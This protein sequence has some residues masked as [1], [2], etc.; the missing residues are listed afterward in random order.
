MSEFERLL[1]ALLNGESADITP[2][3]RMEKFLKNCVDKCGCDDL[4][5]P[6]TRGEVLLYQLAEQMASGGGSSGG[7]LVG[8]LDGTA[9][10]LNNNDITTLRAFAIENNN[11]LEEVTLPNVVS[12]GEYAFN[13]CKYLKKASMPKLKQADRSVF[14]GCQRLTDVYLPLL[15]KASDYMFNSCST[16]KTL[17]LPSVKSIGQVGVGGCEQLESVNLPQVTETTRSSFA[18]NAM[19]TTVNAPLL[20]TLENY[21]FQNCHSIERLDFSNLYT[22]YGYAFSA[23]NSLKTLILRRTSVVCSLKSTNAFGACYHFEGTT[24]ETYNP[25]GDRDGYIYVPR[26]LVDAY[27]TATNWATFAEQFRAIED[28]PEICGEV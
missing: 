28:Y 26:D 8:V 25:N 2:K 20:T 5:T 15:E 18:G 17:D 6:R 14:G 3:S 9:T 22:I 1:T 13:N 23:C 11:T 4:P 12:I 16:L 27:K 7:D 10:S 19:L 24:N 21:C